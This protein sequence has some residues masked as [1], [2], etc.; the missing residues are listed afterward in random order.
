[1]TATAQAR[2]TWLHAS[3]CHTRHSCDDDTC[4]CNAERADL[5]IAQGAALDGWRNRMV[6]GQR[7]S[8]RSGL[9]DT[10]KAQAPLG[11][12]CARRC[13]RNVPALNGAFDLHPLIVF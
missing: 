10:P 4:T 7:Y 2:S 1:M 13:G 3:Q 8:R 5:L 12:G 6:G 9:L 11:L